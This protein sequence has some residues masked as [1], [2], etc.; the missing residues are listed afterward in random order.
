MAAR[1][2]RSPDLVAPQGQRRGRELVAGVGPVER[3]GRKGH[4]AGGGIGNR[5]AGSGSTMGPVPRERAGGRSRA[6]V[7][8]SAAR[9]GHRLRAL[10]HGVAPAAVHV[11]CVSGVCCVW[12]YVV[13]R[14]CGVC[15]N[16]DDDRFSE[17]YVTGIR[18]TTD[19][20]CATILPSVYSAALG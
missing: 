19:L 4:G 3:V 20:L 15:G 14:V 1:T 7:W 13:A 9:D 10:R 11:A 18:Q 5:W 12:M 8:G 17:C 16:V 6:N 2:W